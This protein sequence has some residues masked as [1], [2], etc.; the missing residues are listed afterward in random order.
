MFEHFI[1]YSQSGF[2]REIFNQSLFQLDEE[3]SSRIANNRVI[4]T[5]I[6]RKV[7]KKKVYS[8]IGRSKFIRNF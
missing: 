7:S 5:Q 8:I 6:L 3:E 2:V 4:N 1:N